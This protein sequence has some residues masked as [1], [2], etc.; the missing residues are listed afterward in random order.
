MS[1]LKELFT[2]INILMQRRLSETYTSGCSLKSSG[3]YS[4]VNC[5][6]LLCDFGWL[7]PSSRL[8]Q[9]LCIGFTL[10]LNCKL[11]KGN[12]GNVKK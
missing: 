4:V 11:Q 6:M 8:I 10:N 3:L 5:K 9:R 2:I 1:N 7:D 12:I